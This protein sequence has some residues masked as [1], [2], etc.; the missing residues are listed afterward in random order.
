MPGRRVQTLNFSRVGF[1]RRPFLCSALCSAN[2]AL[3][4]TM[5]GRDARR[6]IQNRGRERSERFLY[7]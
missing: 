2:E 5:D 7:V 1:G 4:T 3:S 6:G